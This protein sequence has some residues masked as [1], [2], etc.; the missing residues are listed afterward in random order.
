MVEVDNAMSLTFS[1]LRQWMLPSLLRVEAASS[2][3]FYPHRLFEAGEVAIPDSMHELGSRTEVVL[4]SVI[5]HAGAHFSEMHSCLDV[6]LYYFGRNTAWSR[7]N[8]IIP[9]RACWANRR[10]GETAGSY[11]R[12]PSRSPGALADRRARRCLRSESHPISRFS[13]IGER[14]DVALPYPRYSLLIAERVTRRGYAAT[15]VSCCLARPTS[16]SNPALSLMA[17]SERTLRSSK[18]FAFLRA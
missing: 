1:C 6:L 8:I 14:R 4:G 5:A 7:S 3:A 2:R 17:M 10:R 18:I 11:R 15:G 16:F 13:L 9:G 12:S